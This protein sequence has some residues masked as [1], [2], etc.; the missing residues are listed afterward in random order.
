MTTTDYIQIS[1][2]FLLVLATIVY[3]FYTYKLVLESRK[4]RE[5]VLKPYI[6]MY[7]DSAETDPTLKF[8][9]IENIGSG[10]ALEV[11][12]EILKDI[13]LS[14]PIDKT[15]ESRNFLNRKYSQFPPNYKFRNYIVSMANNY[16]AKM[17]A[18]I[19]IKCFYKD[20]FNKQ[21]AETFNLNLSDGFSTGK[22]TPPETY[23]GLISHEV[24]N[25]NITLG[26]IN[27]KLVALD[28]IKSTD[29]S[30]DI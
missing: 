17:V 20:I 6:L 21:Y 27:N 23:V 2:S 13:E 9:N 24:K 3:V 16:E 10:V 18:Q 29:Q 26:K 12:F 15:L 19:S 25:L 28:K 8:L 14:H 7:L 5:M 11:S 30:E 22:L 4:S 1:F